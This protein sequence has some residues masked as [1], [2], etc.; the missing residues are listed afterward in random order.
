MAAG[1]DEQSVK[2]EARGAYGTNVVLVDH[3]VR[4]RRAERVDEEQIA[5][6]DR[7]Y[8]SGCEAVVHNAESAVVVEEADGST[9]REGAVGD[10]VVVNGRRVS[11]E[12]NDGP[13]VLVERVRGDIEVGD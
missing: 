8:C 4:T 3:Y 6:M 11:V 5:E 10:A 9:S 1:V 2:D 13:A 7:A 12:E